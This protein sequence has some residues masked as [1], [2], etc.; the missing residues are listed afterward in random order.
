MVT[1]IA[2]QRLLT[3]FGN[4]GLQRLSHSSRYI[5]IYLGNPQNLAI[6]I[7]S[8]EW[9]SVPLGVRGGPGRT[10]TCNQ[11]VMSRRL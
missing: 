3:E 4:F 2:K 5:E 8:M 9:W 6:L 1:K 10:R 11:T 7:R